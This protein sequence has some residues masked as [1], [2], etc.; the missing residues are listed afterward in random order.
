MPETTLLPC[1][2]CGGRAELLSAELRETHDA[3]IECSRCETTGPTTETD[4]EA[5][6]A[7]NRRAS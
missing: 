6:A 7:W 1:P 5:I 3:M 2:F 4:V